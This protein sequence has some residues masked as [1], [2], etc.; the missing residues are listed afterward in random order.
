VTTFDAYFVISVCFV[1]LGFLWILFTRK[2]LTKLQNVPK[3]EWL[4]SNKIKNE[5]QISNANCSQL[6][7]SI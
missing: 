7:E 1:T 6:E 5:T 2:L 4:V 3:T